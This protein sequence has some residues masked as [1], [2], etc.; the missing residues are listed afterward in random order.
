MRDPD[1]RN[2]RLL[3]SDGY[4]LTS[5]PGG[6]FK[7]VSAGHRNACAIRTDG[8]LVCWGLDEYTIL[9]PPG[10]ND[11]VEVISEFDQRACARR[12]NGS[13]TCWGNPDFEPAYTPP[14]NDF[15]E[16]G[17]SRERGCARKTDGSLVCWLFYSTAWQATPTGSFTALD[18]GALRERYGDERSG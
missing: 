4:F 18:G 14:G 16:V 7:A 6:T 11:F 3:G 10:G 9:S 5:P 8:S 13:L 12:T 2:A 1:R 17:M 15:A